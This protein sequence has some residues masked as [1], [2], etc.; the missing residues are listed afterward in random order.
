MS[1]C[2]RHMLQPVV[3]HLFPVLISLRKAFNQSHVFMTRHVKSLPT[4]RPSVSSGNT[5]DQIKF[6]PTASD[7]ASVS[8]ICAGVL[9]PRADVLDGE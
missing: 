9:E 2:E 3:L 8:L 6:W 5:L 7:L 1:S 4:G